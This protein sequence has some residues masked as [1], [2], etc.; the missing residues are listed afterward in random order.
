[1]CVRTL[2]SESS[3]PAASLANAVV[4]VAARAVQPPDLA[5][6]VL[7]RERVEHGDDRRR[8]DPGADQQHR[9]VGLARMKVPRGAATSS[10]SPTASSVWR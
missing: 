5:L 3:S 1:M 8:P 4:A 10:S 6:G 2:G 9:R 7:L